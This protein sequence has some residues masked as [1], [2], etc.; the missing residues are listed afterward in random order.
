MSDVTSFILAYNDGRTGDFLQAKVD[1]KWGVLWTVP[2]NSS[3]ALVRI[4]R[5]F[6][7]ARAQSVRHFCHATLRTFNGDMSILL[8]S[9]LPIRSQSAWRLDSRERIVIPRFLTNSALTSL[10]KSLTEDT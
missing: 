5:Q 4:G 8:V 7:R 10:E 2:S 3:T 1:G 6:R 9:E